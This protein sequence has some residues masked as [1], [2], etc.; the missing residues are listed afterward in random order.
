MNAILVLFVVGFVLLA[1]EV[2]VPGAILGI[3]GGLALLGGVILAFLEYGSTG[4]WTALAVGASLGALM[5][6]VEFWLLPRTPWGK[7]MFLNAAIDGTSQPPPAEASTVMGRAGEAITP[8]S[9][10]GYVLIEGRRY[11]AFSRSGLVAKGADVRVVGVDNFRLI[12]S[13]P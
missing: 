6:F 12:V 7:R 10:S 2:F 1:F 9:P 4:G 3:I 5:L 8:L 13:K 11:E